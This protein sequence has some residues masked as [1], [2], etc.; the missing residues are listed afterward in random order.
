MLFF[1]HSSPLFIIHNWVDSHS[2]FTVGKGMANGLVPYRDLFEQK[3]PLLY[4]FHAFAYII[5]HISFLGV[6]ILEALMMGINLTVAYKISRLYLE[7]I[8]SIVVS[9]FF[10]IFLL[11]QS[12]FAFGDSAE[13]FSIPFFMIFLFLTLRHFKNH[14]DT[15]LKWSYFF[16]NGV[17][18]GCVFWIKYTLVG[19]W[20]GFY[21]AILFICMSNRSWKEL[22]HAV[23]YTFGG[24]L[25]ASIPWFLYF[26]LNHAMKDLFDVYIKFN[27]FTYSSQ[28]STLEKLVNSAVIFGQAINRNFESKVFIVL[29]L[30]SFMFTGKYLFKIEQKL[31][32][33]S[34]VIF[35]ILGVYFGGRD[36]SYYYHII[37]P[38][39]LLGLI[40]IGGVFQKSISK[41]GVLK[42]KNWLILPLI[43]LSVFYLMFSYNSNIQ[44]SRLFNKE[45]P[46][47][48]TFAKIMREEPN[49]TLLNYGALDGGFYLMADIVPNIRYFQTQNIDH[50]LYPENMDEQHR[51]I[52]EGITQFVVV[53]LMGETP[54][55]QVNIPHLSKRYSLVAQQDQLLGGTQYRYLLYKKMSEN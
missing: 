8:P 50:A 42:V 49:P 21:L 9:L 11:N 26:G 55:E 18:I 45:V 12:S 47:Q 14:S 38:W 46:P 1:T 20:I 24:L 3:G 53:R 5:S 36:Y 32:L 13:E 15:P 31:A 43:G 48:Q 2:F 16:I 40:V 7:Q 27:L 29:G 17:L 33:I 52:K 23:V 30:L 54:V 10:P 44:Y 39:S 41:I 35:M 4:G 25:L 51:Y 6:Y 19:A 22:F 28:N 34:T 37:T